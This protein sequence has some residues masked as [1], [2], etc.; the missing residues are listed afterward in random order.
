MAKEFNTAKFA[1]DIKKARGDKPLKDF[2]TEIG[3]GLSTLHRIEGG[4]QP[5]IPAL[6]AIMVFMNWKFEDYITNNK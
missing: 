1:A 4:N 2:S 5:A 6:C 3:I